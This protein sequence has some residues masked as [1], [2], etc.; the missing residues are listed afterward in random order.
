MK[1]YRLLL[2]FFALPA[3]LTA[4]QLVRGTVTSADDHSAMPGVSVIVKGTSVG[5]VTDP[6]GRFEINVPSAN[7]S[8]VFSMIGMESKT[9]A[10]LNKENLEVTL[11]T[12]SNK[13]NEVVVTALGIRRE[14][15]AL[16]YSVQEISGSDLQTAKDPSF[17]NQLSGK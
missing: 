17:V 6:D 13:L 2:F 3:V 4:Q 8:L 15:K 5:T 11:E 14:R 9:I 1:K 16:G 12:K 10:I 7:D